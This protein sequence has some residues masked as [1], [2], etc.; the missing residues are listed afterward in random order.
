MIKIKKKLSEMTL[1]ELWQLFPIRLT[2][3]QPIWKEWFMEERALLTVLL[4]KDVKIHHIGS[5][6]IPGIGAKPIID[7]LVE[8]KVS[9]FSVIKHSLLNNGYLCMN[10]SPA[11]ISFN[12]GYTEDGFSEKVF[13]L[14]LRTPG[15]HDELLFR[16]YLLEHPEIAKDYE[17]LKLSLWKT[18][19]FDRDGYTERKTAFV[20]IIT[21]KAKTEYGLDS[22]K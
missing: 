18:Y 4:P 17:K 3:Y 9:D 5:T 10:E 16:D 11:R 13:H 1:E 7:I 6:A 20:Q 21:Q 15:D 14:H 22:Y 19:E 2:E 12:K 8:A